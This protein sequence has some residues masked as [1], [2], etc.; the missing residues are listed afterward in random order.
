MRVAYV[1]GA[2]SGEFQYLEKSRGGWACARR[3]IAREHTNRRTIYKPRTPIWMHLLRF[4][5]QCPG[6]SWT[7]H[8]PK[9]TRA[10]GHEYMDL[11]WFMVAR[12]KPVIN[13]ENVGNRSPEKRATSR[14]K[15]FSAIC[16]VY[17]LE[18]AVAALWWRLMVLSDG[19]VSITY[20]R[21]QIPEYSSSHCF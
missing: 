1:S 19:P 16:T 4:V 20:K 10:F 2:I 5:G 8:V 3:R 13:L 14:E 6:E 21:H 17:S 18:L 7:V 11:F 15:P 9:V 12:K